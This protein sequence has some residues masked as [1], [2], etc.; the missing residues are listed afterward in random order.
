MP[1]TRLANL[2]K[3]LLI[4]GLDAL[5]LNAGPSLVYLT[6]LHFH[7]SERPVVMLITA[8][9]TPGIVL[10]ELELLKLERLPF[11]I[12]AFPYGENP[13]GWK[14]AFLAAGKAL[15]LEGKVIGVE[16]RSMRLL[17]YDF[18]KEIVG[19][20][21][22]KDAGDMVGALRLHKDMQEVAS[23]RKAV[24]IAQDSL[25]AALRFIKIGITEKEIASELVLQ[26]LRHGSDPDL[27]F[28]PIVSG[29][30]NGANPHALPSE[31]KLQAGDLLVVD[32]GAAVGGYISDL[33][34]TF[35]VGEVEA[36]YRK[37]HRIVLEANAAGRQAGRAG[38]P[39]AAVDQAAR[40]VIRRAGYGEYF[41]HRTGH[42]IG[43]EAHEEPYLR[44]DNV[45]LLEP[46]MVYTVE[47]G[48]YLPGRNGVRIEDNVLI[49][50]GGVECLSDMPRELRVLK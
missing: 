11:E 33:T 37:I 50:A 21:G 6:G 26:L 1:S 3:S 7:I 24:K 8:E 45:Q 22:Y 23:I 46:G 2:R 15:G 47:P 19:K 20:A 25:E 44:G 30:P 18:L 13:A 4:S 31:R 29:G 28:F 34:R 27:P 10:P 35:A 36:E 39:C 16:P 14:G 40:D 42:G 17:E 49:S 9:G 12:K 41:T 48:I 38:A 43:M 32:W 5:A